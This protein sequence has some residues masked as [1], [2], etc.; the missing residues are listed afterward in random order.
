MKDRQLESIRNFSCFFYFVPFPATGSI[1]TT[2][3]PPRTPEHSLT[4]FML[5]ALWARFLFQ[6][7][8][9]TD[10]HFSLQCPY[11]CSQPKIALTSCLTILLNSPE[12]SPNP[13][14]PNFTFQLHLFSSLKFFATF[15]AT[16]THILFLHLRLLASI[17]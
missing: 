17:K 7:Q 13:P 2:P 5:A 3:P 15:P 1:P 4:P 16:H 10:Q 9:P 12:K 6:V 8:P 11:C 14:S